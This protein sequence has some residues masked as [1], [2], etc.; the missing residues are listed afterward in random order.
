MPP[1]A[2]QRGIA[3]VA[4]ES[5]GHSVQVVAPS[6]DALGCLGHGIRAAGGNQIRSFKALS[7]TG[8]VLLI[9][10]PRVEAVTLDAANNP[11]NAQH[12]RSSERR[13][14]DLNIE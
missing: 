11:P 2:R 9:L 4:S 3:R 12:S 1:V 6:L 10:L 13:K 7:A 8:D 5:C 14:R